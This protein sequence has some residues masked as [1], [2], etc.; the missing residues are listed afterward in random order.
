MLFNSY[1][2]NQC[3]LINNTSV[4]PHLN[5]KSIAKLTMSYLLNMTFC[6]LFVH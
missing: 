4:L 1:F 2:A 6:L 3:T 5:I